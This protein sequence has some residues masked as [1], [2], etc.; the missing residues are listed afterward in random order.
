MVLLL[1]ACAPEAPV[2][3]PEPPPL[4][5]AHD[6]EVEAHMKEHFSA[7][8]IAF[9]SLLHGDIGATREKLGWLAEHEAPAGL[10]PGPL[11]K[12]RA[13]AKQGADAERYDQVAM[14]M[15]ELGTRCAACHAQAGAKPE[16]PL[17]DAPA[18]SD[19]LMAHMV[20]HQWAVRALWAG[21]VVPSDDAWRLGAEALG[22]SVLPEAA[23]EVPVVPREDWEAEV[24]AHATAAKAAALSAP[25]ERA[26]AFGEIVSA[27]AGC[28]VEM[29]GE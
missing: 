4:P 8:T 25:A 2:A 3:P 6:E 26:A 20:R 13:T 15:G 22:N 9:E 28:H 12:M 14:A 17:G 23:F 21:L 27:C 11:A 24:G 1:A 7:A 10:P 18:E 16:I 29:R 5:E 19:Q